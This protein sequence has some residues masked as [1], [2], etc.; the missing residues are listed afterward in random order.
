MNV[1]A[2]STQVLSG[3]FKHGAGRIIL[4]AVGSAVVAAAVVAAVAL[5]PSPGGDSSAATTNAA[6]LVAAQAQHDAL[7]DG[8]AAQFPAG[9]L[10]GSPASRH[11]ERTVRTTYI[12]AS[13][14]QAAAVKTGIVD[15][16]T[17]RLA[18]GEPLL[19]DSVLVVS[20]DTEAAAALDA[21]ADG[22]RILATL[23]E[24]QENVADLRGS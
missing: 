17:I 13:A 3:T 2:V 23:G 7:I 15:A 22:N 14:E 21:I 16:N 8:T 12:V 5:R 18:V 19:L 10:S 4:L 1:H 24:P 6:N 11:S 9:S 20:S